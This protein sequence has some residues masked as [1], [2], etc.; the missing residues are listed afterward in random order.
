MYVSYVSTLLDINECT[1]LSSDETCGPHVC[2]NYAGSFFCQCMAG[3][4]YGQNIQTCIG[5]YSSS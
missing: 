5:K 2:R 1:T 3:Y 4:K